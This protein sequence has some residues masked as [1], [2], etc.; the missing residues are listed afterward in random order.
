MA[1]LVYYL[2][3]IYIM[4]D[5]PKRSP[6]LPLTLK[7]SGKSRADLWAFAALVAM[8]AGLEENNKLC[9]GPGDLPG[10][11]AP[12]CGHIYHLEDKCKI[13]LPDTLGI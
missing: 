10:R 8:R 13:G 5:W 6:S 3:K 4:K 9:N 11:G 12:G 1:R 2:E 7:E